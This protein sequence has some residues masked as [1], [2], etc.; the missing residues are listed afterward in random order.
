MENYYIKTG[1]ENMQFESVERLLKQTYWAK[2]RST[3]TIL[4]SI[5]N[6]ICYG[7][8]LSGDNVQVGFS[9]VITDYSTTYYICDVIVDSEYRGIGMGKALLA[10]IDEDKQNL[11]LMGILTTKD[12]HGL[13]EKYGFKES[14]TFMMKRRKYIKSEKDNL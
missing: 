9:R 13:Y 7:V 12:A 10:A 5:E 1:I 14:K 11:G 6:S 4:K 8:F 2:N 3:E